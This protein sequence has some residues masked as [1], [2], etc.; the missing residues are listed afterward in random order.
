MNK[1]IIM[2]DATC[3][4][5]EDLIKKYDVKIVPLHV[6]FKGDPNDYLD[7]K[8]ITVDEVYK[9]VEET[10]NTPVT[11]AINVQEFIEY[12]KEYINQGYDIIF[13]G[14][15]SGLSSTYNNACIASKEYEE[16]RIEV[17]DSMNLSTG[18]GLLVLKMGVFREEGLDIHT[19]AN[20]VRELVPF[21]SAKFCI[22][23]LDYLY[24][25]GRC[26]GM[27]KMLAHMLKIHPVAKVINNKLTVYK[28]P[29]GIY[30]KAVDEQID[31]FIKDLPNMDKSCV[32]VTHSGKMNGEDE[33]IYD[34][35]TKY[36][37]KENVHVTR[38]GC[39]ISSHC[40]PKTVGILY[41]LNK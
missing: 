16:G 40:G 25:G 28:K 29:R 23:R 22:D 4:L 36:I 7:G 13:T 15:G 8:T 20:K 32:F 34:K 30:I 24:K 19:I 11:G 35:V 33:Y 6:T 3:D 39:V 41:I 18:I 17:V 21:V 10:G 37:P 26:S 31:E 27:T 14:I 1:I 38:A 2:A 5:S 12:F 9:M